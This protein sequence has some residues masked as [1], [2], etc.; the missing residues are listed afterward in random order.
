M[1]QCYSIIKDI[2]NN[3]IVIRESAELDKDSYSPLCEETYA[4]EALVEAAKDGWTSLM[5]ALRTRN[6]YPPELY[7]AKIAMAVAT[8]IKSNDET[9]TDLYFNDLELLSSSLEAEV[10]AELSSEA[11]DLDD[12]LGDDYEDGI[13]ED[14]PINKIDSSLKVA[15]NE[16]GDLD[17]D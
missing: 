13:D 16:Y 6:L 9:S 12:L 11:D 15:D 4:I 2:E 14:S 17:E 3:Q 8:L 10:E 7:A 1:K 5:G